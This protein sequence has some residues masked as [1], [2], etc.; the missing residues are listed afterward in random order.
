MVW[1][2]KR[3]SLLALNGLALV[4]LLFLSGCAT[5]H[6]M[7]VNAGTERL[8]LDGKAMVLMSV[9]VGNQYSPDYQ[10]QI[11]VAHVETPDAKEKS[12]RHNFKTDL[13]GT[14]SS[15][16]GTR[17]L[18][19]MEL[20]PG[21]YVVRG[22]TCMYRSLF[23]AATCLLPIHADIEV[24]PGTVTYIGRVSGTM[25]ERGDGEFRAG[26]VI[27]LIDQSVTGFAQSTFDVVIADRQDEDLPSYRQLFPALASA[28]I[29]VRVMP[30]FDRARAQ[31]W[32]DSNGG[33]EQ[34]GEAT[35]TGKA[36]TE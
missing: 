36:E 9:E 29:E 10:P 11:L 28:D 2:N 33:S 23:I 16:A 32:W 19:R 17:Y 14:V 15:S 3:Q 1:G 6:E 24:A 22:A 7:G 18:L 8:D 34:A 27:P 4:A 30:P 35:V 26:P 21:R 13:E 20:D 31:A 12:D 5:V 25:R